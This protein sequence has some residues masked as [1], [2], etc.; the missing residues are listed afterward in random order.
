MSFDPHDR[1]KLRLDSPS[2]SGLFFGRLLANEPFVPLQQLFVLAKQ[3]ARRQRLKVARNAGDMFCKISR[4]ARLNPVFPSSAGCKFL[5]L[6][7]EQ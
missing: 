6:D 2:E 4:S 1:F 5:H 7:D 3:T